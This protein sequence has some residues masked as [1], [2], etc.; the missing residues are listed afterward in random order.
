MRG[1]QG[2]G[3]G[4]SCPLGEKKERGQVFTQKKQNWVRIYVWCGIYW[5]RFGGGN[6]AHKGERGSERGGGTKKSEGVLGDRGGQ[7]L[8][9]KP[10]GGGGGTHPGGGGW[11]TPTKNLSFF[12]FFNGGIRPVVSLEMRTKN[13]GPG[14]TWGKVGPVPPKDGKKKGG[15]KEKKNPKK[16]REGGAPGGEGGGGERDTPNKR[17]SAAVSGGG[18]VLVG[19]PRGGPAAARA[20]CQ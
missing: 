16:Q 13:G 4:A 11:D 9:F 10:G 12:F 17:T 7:L 14:G 15:E 1:G 2:Q 20:V 8:L 5:V 19:V 18:C 6:G 3:G